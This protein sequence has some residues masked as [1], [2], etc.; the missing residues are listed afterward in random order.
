MRGKNV[1]QSSAINIHTMKI[2][3]QSGANKICRNICSTR[4][5]VAKRNGTREK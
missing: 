1:G 3:A 2:Q 4:N 5:K